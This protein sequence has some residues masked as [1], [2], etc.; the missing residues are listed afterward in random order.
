MR[1]TVVAFD[2]GDLWVALE[3]VSGGAFYAFQHRCKTTGLEAHLWAQT[4]AEGAPKGHV[5]VFFLGIDAVGRTVYFGPVT[6]K[7]HTPMAKKIQ[8]SETVLD[9]VRTAKRYER[10][11]SFQPEIRA[12]N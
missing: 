9:A 6:V 1:P 11:P 3:E 10:G 5:R 2:L 8:V 4:P 12:L 7:G